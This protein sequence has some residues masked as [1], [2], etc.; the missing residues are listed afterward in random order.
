MYRLEKYEESHETYKQLLK[1]ASS[2]A[3][4]DARDRR[5]NL[6][7][8]LAA[9][10]L[11]AN[12]E[13]D[14]PSRGS[15]DSYATVFNEACALVGM[16][17]Y[18]DAIAALE[19]GQPTCVKQFEEDGYSN[20]ELEAELAF[21]H[22]L[23]GFVAMKRAELERVRLPTD[24][25][26][27]ADNANEESVRKY[28]E[29]ASRLF[30]AVLKLKTT[31]SNDVDQQLV[32]VAA[33]NLICLNREANLFD[34]RKKAKLLQGETLNSKLVLAQ[35]YVTQFNQA[36]LYFYSNQVRIISRT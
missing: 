15:N 20:E 3:D 5:A 23:R 28:E 19:R 35:R 8:T 16:Q 6:L 17:R 27:K 25:S 24:S 1:D 11:W 32:A 4:S 14:L 33:N 36:L 18:D 34:S 22:V 26:A 21:F 13:V 30:S 29:E 31:G 12:R 2:T 9:M 7:G 10:T